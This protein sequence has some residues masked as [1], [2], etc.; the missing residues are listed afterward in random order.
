MRHPHGA[1]RRGRGGLALDGGLVLAAILVHRRYLQ[2]TGVK[3]ATCDLL[4]VSN[5]P[6][7]R[8]NVYLSPV[9]PQIAWLLGNGK[10]LVSHKI[11]ARSL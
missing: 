2:D 4:G 6:K 3:D 11:K 1:R 9:F 7:N 10:I 5:R 8:P